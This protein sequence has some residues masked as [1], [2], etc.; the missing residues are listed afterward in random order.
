MDTELMVSEAA[1]AS[2]PLHG[3]VEVV[4]TDE[5]GL[6]PGLTGCWREGSTCRNGIRCSV[7]GCQRCQRGCSRVAV[8]KE[9]PPMALLLVARPRRLF[10]N[11]GNYLEEIA[12]IVLIN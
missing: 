7:A 12:K 4:I 5:T 9:V 8:L 10:T 2:A 6:V 3:T 1:A 11:L